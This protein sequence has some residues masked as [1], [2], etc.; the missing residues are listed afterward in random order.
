MVSGNG[1]TTGGHHHTASQRIPPAVVDVRLQRK[2]H[3]I[4]SGCVVRRVTVKHVVFDHPVVAGITRSS[5]G[6][7]TVDAVNPTVR[8]PEKRSRD[9]IIKVKS[10]LKNNT[11]YKHTRVTGCL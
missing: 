3:A 1:A 10:T 11:Q 6:R 2:A 7:G 4:H 8:E 9:A 5:V